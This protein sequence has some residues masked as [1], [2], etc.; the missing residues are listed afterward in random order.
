MKRCVQLFLILIVLTLQLP[1]FAQDRH[2]IERIGYWGAGVDYIWDM[3]IQ[4]DYAYLA[5][6]ESG[7]RIIDVSDPEQM[8]L[9]SFYD[10]GGSAKGIAV[11]GDFAYV[12][13]GSRGLE[14]VDV[15]DPRN[16]E[17]VSL[18]QSD[19]DAEDVALKDGHVYVLESFRDDE[20]REEYSRLR[21]VDIENPS[22]PRVIG[23]CQFDGWFYFIRLA[24][25]S[26][27]AYTIGWSDDNQ[28]V[29]VIDIS[30]LERPVLVEDNSWQ[31]IGRICDMVIEGD[32]AYTTN[33]NGIEPF[34]VLNLSDPLNPEK[35]GACRLNNGRVFGLAVNGDYAY[36]A[37]IEAPAYADTIAI[38]TIDI[39]D[40]DR[41]RQI[42]SCGVTGDYSEVI[43]VSGEHLY[44]GT[45]G[46]GLRVVDVS[47]PD[48]PEEVGFCNPRWMGDVGIIG[49]GDYL[50]AGWDIFDVSDPNQPE[51]VGNFE[52][53][54]IRQVY[55]GIIRG[56][57]LYYSPSPPYGSPIYIFEITGPLEPQLIDVCNILRDQYAF[58]V[59]DDLIYFASND[60]LKIMDISDPDDPQPIGFY[61]NE[62][63]NEWWKN[64]GLIK[65]IGEYVLISIT[66]EDWDNPED[67]IYGGIRIVDISDPTQPVEVATYNPEEYYSYSNLAFSN[68]FFCY[69]SSIYIEPVYQ[70]KLVIFNFSDPSQPEI[71]SIYEDI[72]QPKSVKVSGDFAFIADGSAGIKVIDLSDIYHPELVGYYDTPGYAV[73]IYVSDH[74]AYVADE[75]ML[76]VYDCSLAMGLG[77]DDPTATQPVKLNLL[78]AYPNP[79]NSQTTVTFTLPQAGKV[80]LTMFDMLGREV[81]RISPS[82]WLQSGEH[83]INIDANR[84]ATGNYLLRLQS[85]NETQVQPITL[86]K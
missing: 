13:D 34:Q 10:V 83:N 48:N 42:G 24:D 31:E 75:T 35:V 53:E 1:S 22:E 64:V 37:N 6:G 73:D 9:V 74:I 21:I 52:P 50:Y 82:G 61:T 85:G 19:W 54:D 69:I 30:E 84:L 76:G 18:I 68:D 32:H 25:N 38:F 5:S 58:D 66:W 17:E 79:F 67:G 11:E 57:R 7:L 43:A 45:M 81:N 4:G 71:A 23:S 29:N 60:T 62:E 40:L 14:I 16:L 41:P 63:I 27:Y 59:S 12:A 15:S 65:V 78:S 3:A 77:V 39:S 80:N 28:H 44:V 26:D 72:E 86:V 8:E 55:S 47:E 56:E 49:T 36:V 20:S 46:D 33:R 70:H 2:N 51:L